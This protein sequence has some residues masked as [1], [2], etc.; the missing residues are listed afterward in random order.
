M[1]VGRTNKQDRK[2][3]IEKDGKEIK[4]KESAEQE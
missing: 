4:G 2:I 3:I 1:T